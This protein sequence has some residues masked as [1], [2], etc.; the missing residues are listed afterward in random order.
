MSGSGEVLAQVPAAKAV[1]VC[2]RVTL[3]EEAKALLKTDMTP[4]Q[5]LTRLIDAKQPLDAIRFLAHA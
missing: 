5:Y 2:E 1:E 3:G 4:K